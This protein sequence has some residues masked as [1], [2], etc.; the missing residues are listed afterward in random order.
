MDHTDNA[1]VGAA[2]EHASVWDNGAD[3]VEELE[4]VLEV[5]RLGLESFGPARRPPRRAPRRPR[6]R[7]S[8]PCTCTTATS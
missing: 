5:R 6:E 4:H 1:F 7:C 3:L 2:H 8:F